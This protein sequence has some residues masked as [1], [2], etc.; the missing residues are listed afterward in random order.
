MSDLLLNVTDET[1]AKEVL[2]SEIPVLVDF[3]APWCGPCK[4]ITPVLENIAPEYQEKLRIAK[5]NVDENSRTPVK[6]GVRSIPNLLIFKNGEVVANEVGAMSLTQ[7]K[8]FIDKA[9]A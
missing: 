7:M 8:S 1:F 9:I 5:M 6:Y 2:D 3:W 4:M